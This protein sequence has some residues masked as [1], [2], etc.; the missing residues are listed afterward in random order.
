MR[1]IEEKN[2]CRQVLRTWG[3]VGLVV[4]FRSR[5][6]NFDRKMLYGQSQNS[7]SKFSSG[8]R[9]DEIEREIARAVN[10]SFKGQASRSRESYMCLKMLNAILPQDLPKMMRICLSKHLS[11]PEIN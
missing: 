1:A 4:L 11:K 8:M 7:M 10:N 6:L 3:T 9:L 2:F 5:V